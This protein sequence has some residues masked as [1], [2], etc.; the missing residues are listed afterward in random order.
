MT[1]AH[2]TACVKDGRTLELPSDADELELRAG[3]H[4]EVLI[5]QS[6]SAGNEDANDV[7]LQERYR[8][9]TDALY[10]QADSET[11]EPGVHSN[12]DKAQVAE[13]VRAKHRTK[14]LLI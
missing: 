3:D 1:T 12:P 5:T 11:R 10:E 13:L 14:G 9:I 4:V 2:F 7:T 8:Q 6:S